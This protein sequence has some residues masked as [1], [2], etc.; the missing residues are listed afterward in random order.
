MKPSIVFI[1]LFYSTIAFS[2]NSNQG[3]PTGQ[4]KVEAIDA[5]LEKE[6][7]RL[8]N[9]ERERLG[10]PA[11]EWQ[12]E[13]AYAARYHAQDMAADDYFDHDSYDRVNGELVQSC[14]TFERIRKFYQS[15]FANAENISTR[16]SAESIVKGWMNSA[17]HK[18][19]I[20]NPKSKFV[21]IGFFKNETSTYKT[22]CVQCFGY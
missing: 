2:Q 7:L 14:N 18:A 15:G 9:L 4:E 20:L 17:G 11:L 6:V 13:L 1:V 5:A 12:E 3:C 19:N 10:L 8:V 22:Y 16:N 21:G